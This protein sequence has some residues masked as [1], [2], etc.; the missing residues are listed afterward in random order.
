MEVLAEVPPM[1]ALPASLG[2]ARP[3][4]GLERE[5]LLQREIASLR[6]SLRASL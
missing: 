2:K 1:P 5:R 4:W 6:A 3:T